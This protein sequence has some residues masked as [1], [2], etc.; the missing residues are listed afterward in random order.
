MAGP[1]DM[2]VIS[3]IRVIPLDHCKEQTLQWF[4]NIADC[5]SRFPGHA[6]TELFIIQPLNGVEEIMNI[7]RFNSYE[8]LMVWERSRQRRSY[9]EKGKSL[10]R[11]QVPALQVTGIEYWFD[12]SSIE[13]APAKWKMIVLTV[14]IIFTLLNTVAPFCRSIFLA[15]SIP[16]IF[17]SLL[18]VIIMVLLMTYIIMPFLSR[19]LFSWLHRSGRSANII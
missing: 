12:H 15:M 2:P 7:F 4:E 16:K 13:K 11:Q 10:F 19:I 6:T 18:I 5:A 17:I 8:Q 3:I 14:V 1:V 9:L